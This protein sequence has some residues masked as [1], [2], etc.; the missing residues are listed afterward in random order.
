LTD[1]SP[2]PT[3]TVPEDTG[4]NSAEENLQLAIRDA[5]RVVY[6]REMRRLVSEVEQRAVAAET[7]TAALKTAMSAVEAHGQN[8]QV[9]QGRYNLRGEEEEM[10]AAIE[11]VEAA[12]LAAEEAR[13]K[14]QELVRKFE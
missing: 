9:H 11:A 6:E 8:F 12:N 10:A 7:A 2:L 1:T 5:V 4:N 14:V 3:T 13:E